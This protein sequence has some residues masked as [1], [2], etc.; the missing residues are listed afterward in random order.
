MSSVKQAQIQISSRTGPT[1]RWWID[2]LAKLSI[3]LNV[4]VGVIADL[5]CVLYPCMYHEELDIALATWQ[6]TDFFFFFTGSSR[7]CSKKKIAMKRFS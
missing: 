7:Y 6:C 1:T 3:W 2:L 5:T 4:A